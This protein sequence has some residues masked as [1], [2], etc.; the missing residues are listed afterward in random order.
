MV[1][2]PERERPAVLSQRRGDRVVDDA[3]KGLPWSRWHSDPGRLER[4]RAIL[5]RGWS[6]ACRRLDGCRHPSRPSHPRRLLFATPIQSHSFQIRARQQATPL[7]EAAAFNALVD[8][9]YAEATDG[10]LAVRSHCTLLRRRDFI[11]I[12]SAA[13]W[14]AASP[15]QPSATPRVASKPTPR[16][17]ESLLDTDDATLRWV[18]QLGIEWVSLGESDNFESGRKGVWSKWQIENFQDR[19][20]SYGLQLHSLTIPAHWLPAPRQ[21]IDEL[22]RAIDDVREC[23]IAAGEAQVKVVEWQWSDEAR[24]GGAISPPET[25]EWLALFGVRVMAA[26]EHAGVKMSLRPTSTRSNLPLHVFESLEKLESFFDAVT[27]PA[28]GITMFHSTMADLEIGPIEAVRRISARGRIHH[29]VMGTDTSLHSPDTAAEGVDGL[30]V[31]RAYKECGYDL[32]IVSD[33]AAELPA[34]L[35][36][37]RVGCCFSHGYL[38]GLMQAVYA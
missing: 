3:A 14:A 35:R 20:G 36:A 7:Q 15:A 4:I 31:M 22:H 17:A 30:E 34:D 24:W 28:N 16:L 12:A 8:L 10:P 26:A 19:L 13:P 33:H 5:A 9:G 29:V 1:A 27:S 25:L 2:G 38:R 6:A 21:S 37:T 23:L 32:A 11:P 18:A